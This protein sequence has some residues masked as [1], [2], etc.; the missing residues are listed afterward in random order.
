MAQ[1]DDEIQMMLDMQKQK[2]PQKMTG[3][4]EIDAMLAAQSGIKQMPQE[5]ESKVLNESSDIPW[6]QRALVKNIGGS[7]QEQVAY[8]QEKNPD[9]EVTDIDNEV[10]ARKRGEKDWKKLDPTGATSIGEAIQDVTDV[11]YDV[12][13]GAGSTLGA[14]K[15]GILGGAGTLGIGAIPAA[16]AGGA[17]TS[18]GLEALRQKL[19]QAAGVAKETNIKD[20]VLSG[21]LGA[22]PVPFLG[23]GATGKQLTKAVQ[24]P[25][26]V[27]KVL[28]RAQLEA[29]PEGAKITN[30][31]K[32]LAKSLLS[33]TQEGVIGKL[34]KAAVGASSGIPSE[35]LKT[36]TDKAS[37]KTILDLREYGGIKLNP[38]KQ[39]TNLELSD[40]IEKGGVEAIGN[41]AQKEVDKVQTAL[42]ESGQQIGKFLDKATSEGKKL[43]IE[44]YAQPFDNLYA[45]F[46]AAAKESDSLALREAADKVKSLREKYFKPGV[47][48]VSPKTAFTLK[49]ELADL[50]DFNRTPIQPGSQLES[51]ISSAERALRNDIYEIIG[52]KEAQKAYAEH[53]NIQEGIYKFFKTRDAAIN[54]LKNPETL[55]APTAKSQIKKFDEKYKTNLG[56]LSDIATTWKYF[57][58]PPA[59]PIVGGGSGQFWRGTG[60]GAAA[61]GLA[62]QAMGVPTAI[63]AGVGGLAGG[64]LTSP[65]AIKKGLQSETAVSRAGEAIAGLPGIRQAIESRGQLQRNIP[66][67][68]QPLLSNQ[69]L[70]QLVQQT[71]SLPAALEVWNQMWKNQGE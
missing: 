52:G 63:G 40:W 1:F 44:K 59:Q 39:Y 27:R 34:P 19:G 49:G 66:L 22:A 3:D 2:S 57:G 7:T 35:S 30:A 20:I 32:N 33:E 47:T 46:D 60:A 53:A 10:V 8:L 24:N 4:S 56:G 29:I 26:L 16:M 28:E 43:N 41:V 50:I 14:A 15:A 5:Q 17:A 18:A 68:L 51:A 70:A 48:E 54:T 69:G 12:L 62:A 31:Q 25:S 55:R 21:A 38:N 67:E 11:G 6:W 13:A 65:M 23:T 37:T 61:G 9:L 45:Q 36:A 71:G 58:R 42:R 64:F